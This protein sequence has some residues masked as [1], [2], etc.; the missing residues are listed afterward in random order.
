MATLQTYVQ[1]MW[2]RQKSITRKLGAALGQSANKELRVAVLAG[3]VI[4]AA[5]VK[6][7]VDKGV[8]SDAE[9]LATLNQARDDTFADEPPDPAT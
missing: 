8:V 3:D 7:L 6:T 9:L 5:V 1:E 4:L 2:Q